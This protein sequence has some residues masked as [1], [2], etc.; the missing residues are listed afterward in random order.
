LV[1]SLCAVPGV[2]KLRAPVLAKGEPAIAVEFPVVGS[3]HEAAIG[4][5]K[6]AILTLSD[7]EMGV[8]VI[9]SELL[10]AVVA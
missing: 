3:N 5:V 7:V 4:L 9:A 1:P 10:H 6:F 8:Y 2:V